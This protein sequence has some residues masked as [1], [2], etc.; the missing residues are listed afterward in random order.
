MTANLHWVKTEGYEFIYQLCLKESK[1][2]S[3]DTYYYNQL[4]A[5]WCQLGNRYK[6]TETER[7]KLIKAGKP[8]LF[9]SIKINSDNFRENDIINSLQKNTVSQIIF[10]KKI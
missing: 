3:N 2:I 5:K 1:N 10:I 4:V 9:Q 6:S 8:Q 7:K